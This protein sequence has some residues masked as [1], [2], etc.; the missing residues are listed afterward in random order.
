MLDAI[1]ALLYIAALYLLATTILNR[2]SESSASK[3]SKGL[4][5]L[6]CALVF[7]AGGV[8]QSISTENGYVLSILKMPS[9][10]FVII[11]AIVLLSCL[12]KPKPLRNLFIFLIPLSTAAIAGDVFTNE[13]TAQ[14]THYSPGVTTHVLLSILAYSLLTIATLQALFLAY[15]NRQ[16]KNKQLR[17][18]LGIMP[19]LQSMESLLFELLWAGQIL[20]TL[21]IISGA[22]FIEDLFAQH[23]VH[24]TAFSILSWVIYAV[25]LSGR[26]FLGWRGPSA[27]RWTVGGFAA[28]M[29]A[30]FGSKLVLEIILNRV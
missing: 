11:N 3:S 7:H 12:S 18:I 25:L 1:S 24:K 9:L 27:I 8:Y 17:G 23:L 30:Y 26:H 19:P 10:F 4:I 15:Q 14:A 22:I 28:L 29:L 6:A 16:L 21:S 2:N 5:L 20:L 13:S